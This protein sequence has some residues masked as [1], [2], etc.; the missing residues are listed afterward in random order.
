M[1]E[2]VELTEG[3]CRDLL[4][5]GVV[6]RVALLVGGTPQII[7][8]NYGVVDD[9]VVFRTAAT[10]MLGVH[11]L[12]SALA[13]EVDHLDHERHRGWSVLATGRCELV[14]DPEL[15]ARIQG[16]WDPRPWAGG[17]RTRYLRLRWTRLTGRRLGVGWTS[18]DETP[19]R[20]VLES[21]PSLDGPGR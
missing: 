14:T 2:P 6:G 21:V 16:S 11:A 7:P 5:A 4:A 13:F 19:V 3:K 15:I 17:V 10:T 12:G 18:R 20:R 9:A 8:V 1:N